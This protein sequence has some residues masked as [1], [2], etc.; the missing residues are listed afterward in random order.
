M[1]H[2]LWVNISHVTNP[3]YHPEGKSKVE[4]FHGTLHDVMSQKLRD[5]INAWDIYLHQILVA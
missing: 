1:Q 2:V 4:L 3:Y 5:N